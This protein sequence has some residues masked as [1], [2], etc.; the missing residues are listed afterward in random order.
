MAAT[1]IRLRKLF[2]ILLI[3]STAVSWDNEEMEL[4]DLVEEINRNFYEV[5]N[6]EQVY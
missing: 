1:I 4:F 2:L 6:V 5:L 3:S